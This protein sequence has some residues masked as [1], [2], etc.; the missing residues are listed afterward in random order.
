MLVVWVVEATGLGFKMILPSKGAAKIDPF[1][2]TQQSGVD[3]CGMGS[4]STTLGACSAEYHAVGNVHLLGRL[5]R[6]PEE[7]A[8]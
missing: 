7:S 1:S 4:P 6:L 2:E 8:S 5:A 3:G